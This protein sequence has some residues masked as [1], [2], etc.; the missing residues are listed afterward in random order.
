[1]HHNFIQFKVR[2]VL[3]HTVNVRTQIL[4]KY[5]A[6]RDKPKTTKHLEGTHIDTVNT[7]TPHRKD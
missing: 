3:I 6:H 7:Q 2:V 1:M 5:K 4:Q